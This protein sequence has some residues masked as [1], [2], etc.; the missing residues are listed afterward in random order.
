LYAQNY[1]I[2]FALLFPV[3]GL[4]HDYELKRVWEKNEHM[5]WLVAKVLIYIA[6]WA[7]LLLSW[8]LSTPHMNKLGNL[9]LIFVPIFAMTYSFMIFKYKGGC[10]RGGR[11]GQHNANAVH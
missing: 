3:A 7:I 8:I 9:S 6:Y 1:G 2:I 10:Y 11:P 5:G 4:L